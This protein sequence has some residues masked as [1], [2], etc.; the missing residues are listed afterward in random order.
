M[1]W[2]STV[3]RERAELMMAR[4]REDNVAAAAAAEATAATEIIFKPDF[5]HA[6]FN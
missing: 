1:G 5:M 2:A 6:W 4:E 3:H